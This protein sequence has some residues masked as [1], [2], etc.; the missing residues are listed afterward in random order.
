V[1]LEAGHE[2]GDSTTALEYVS[3]A[4]VMEESVSVTVRSEG[5]DAQLLVATTDIRR[6]APRISPLRFMD[7]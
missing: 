6:T 2:S 3:P 4:H 1:S 5:E 7:R